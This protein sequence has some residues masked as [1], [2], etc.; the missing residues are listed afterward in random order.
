MQF[1]INEVKMLNEE[2]K[3]NVKNNKQLNVAK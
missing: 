3:S 1:V 2:I